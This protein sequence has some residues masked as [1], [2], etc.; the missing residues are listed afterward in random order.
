MGAQPCH[1]RGSD[2]LP[3]SRDA[4]HPAISRPLLSL[5]LRVTFTLANLPLVV[6]EHHRALQLVGQAGL[7]LTAEH[8][9]DQ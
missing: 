8:G 1:L 7:A 3:F 2:R 6:L 5:R 9:L 4:H